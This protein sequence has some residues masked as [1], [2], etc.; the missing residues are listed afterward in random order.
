MHGHMNVKLVYI[1]NCF[2]VHFVS[3][4]GSHST[5]YTLIVPHTYERWPADG[6]KKQRNMLPQ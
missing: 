2:P 6:L 4:M 5:Q 3:N 1:L